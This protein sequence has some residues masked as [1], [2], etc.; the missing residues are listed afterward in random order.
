MS[1][2]VITNHT[3]GPYCVP[4]VHVHAWTSLATLACTK[5]EVLE[6]GTYICRDCEVLDAWRCE[7]VSFDP[8]D[9]EAINQ[10]GQR[11]PVEDV[12]QA[13][14]QAWLSLLWFPPWYVFVPEET[15]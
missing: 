5:E 11:I 8:R 7:G 6:A 13:P 2:I 15:P 12:L 14:Q 1:K 9:A 10:A 3:C 4:D